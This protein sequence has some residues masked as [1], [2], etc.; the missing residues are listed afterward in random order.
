MRNVRIFNDP[1]YCF[2]QRPLSWGLQTQYFKTDP[3]SKM[4]LT[5][6][7]PRKWLTASKISHVHGNTPSSKIFMPLAYND[8]VTLLCKNIK[9]QRAAP[10]VLS[11]DVGLATNNKKGISKN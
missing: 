3:A 8:N 6:E 7:T 5:K 4:Y 10:L 9:K 11:K 1:D 2:G